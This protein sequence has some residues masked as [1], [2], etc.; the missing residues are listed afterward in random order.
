MLRTLR[1]LLA[2]ATAVAM[3]LG[4][5]APAAADHRP[6]QNE[7]TTAED[8]LPDL[9]VEP[10][11]DFH[12]QI[13]DGRR[14]VRFTA[15]IGNRGDG[16]LE[17]SGSRTST[18]T[19][20][21]AVVQHIYQRAGGYVSVPTQA[22]FRHATADRHNRWHLLKAAE[23]TL[24][25]PGEVN[26]LVAH[27]EGFCLT[28]DTRLGGT[29]VAGYNGCVEGQSDSRSITEGIS[30]EWSRPYQFSVWGQWID[31]TALP[32]P[33]RYCVAA[34]ADP[35][36]LLTEKNKAN[37]TASALLDLTSNSVTVVSSGC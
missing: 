37:N 17:I 7:V 2:C 23:Y 21:M 5:S 1:P 29:A 8:L 16:P 20:D 22:V 13:V 24:R 30:V 36:G 11:S 10:L 35:L 15:S 34:T 28:D 19:P 3:L 27:R 25:V 4:G 14:V 32:L 12:V 31:L 18:A 26:P 33:G 6:A 9:Q